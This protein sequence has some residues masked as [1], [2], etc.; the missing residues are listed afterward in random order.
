MVWVDFFG[1]NAEAPIVLGSLYSG[2][3]KSG[4]HTKNNDLKVF[5]TRSGTK[6]IVNDAE[7]SIK[8]EDAA[9]SFIKFKGDGN[10][11]L[12]VVKNLSIKV[13]ENMNVSVQND[14]TERV[15]HNTYYYSE[16]L[17]NS[18]SDNK[19]ERIGNYYYQESG[20]ANIQTLKGSLLMRGTTLSVLQGGDDVKISK[21]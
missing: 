21:G 18:I 10:V 14:K 13:G 11:T 20:N 3:Q 19:A 9:E 16:N 4:F 12:N 6:R 5:Q 1:H 7:G 8:E 17:S 2:N 15:N